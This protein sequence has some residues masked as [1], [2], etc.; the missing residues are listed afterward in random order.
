MP[1]FRSK[2]LT[3]K[4]EETKLLQGYRSMSIEMQ[5]WRS[6]MEDASVMGTLD[7]GT[8]YY[9]VLD[10]HGGEEVA[11]FSRD[12]LFRHLQGLSSHPS[13]E[14]ITDAFILTDLGLQAHSRELLNYSR[15]PKKSVTHASRDEC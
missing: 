7:S 4:V 12:H 9:A 3:S 10:G 15:N 5:G 6:N 11:R 8:R 1:T 13:P 14:Q 2:P